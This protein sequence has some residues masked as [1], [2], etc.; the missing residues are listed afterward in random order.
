ML[1]RNRACAD[2]IGSAACAAQCHDRALTTDPVR[3]PT[4]PRRRSGI[5]PGP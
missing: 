3:V 2:S 1:G 4:N 5:R